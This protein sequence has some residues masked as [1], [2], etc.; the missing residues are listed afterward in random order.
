L[1]IGT[2]EVISPV[3]YTCYDTDQDKE[4]KIKVI[5]KMEN[6]HIWYWSGVSEGGRA[7]TGVS[8]MLSNKG[9]KNLKRG[10]LAS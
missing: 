5:N 6:M 2:K 8:V 1:A 7:R 10:V 4:Q 3:T 9:K